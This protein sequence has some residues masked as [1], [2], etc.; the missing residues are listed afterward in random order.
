[1]RRYILV[2]KNNWLVSSAVVFSFQFQCLHFDSIKFICSQKCS[3]HSHI[4]FI[5]IPTIS[6][7]VLPSS[8]FKNFNNSLSSCLEYDFSISLTFVQ[9]NSNIVVLAQQTNWH[10]LLLLLLLFG[11]PLHVL[12]D[13]QLYL[14]P[15]GNVLCQNIYAEENVA[16]RV[17]AHW[18]Q[19]LWHNYTMGSVWMGRST[20]V[21]SEFS[22]I[23]F[24]IAFSS[25]R[26]ATKWVLPRHLFISAWNCS[27]KV[28]N[29]LMHDIV[30]KSWV[31][32]IDP[33]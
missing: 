26:V 11:M 30:I 20:K 8:I 15:F 6:A 27:Y 2:K 18:P 28:M 5:F 33:V 7:F 17:N 21:P 14:A 1:M 32:R 16:E 25:C 10:L 23:N 24:F 4:F 9:N 13:G 29:F 12:L 19:T 3:T 31:S 22:V